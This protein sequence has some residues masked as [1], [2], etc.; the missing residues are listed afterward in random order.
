MTST[1]RLDIRTACGGRLSFLACAAL[2]ACALA[3]AAD[4]PRASPDQPPLEPLDSAA[5][6][7]AAAA[8]LLS[9]AGF[10]GTPAEIDALHAL[11]LDR[12]VE[13]ILDGKAPGPAA[14]APPREVPSL[15]SLARPVAR[16]PR[17]ELAGLSRE[18]RQKKV[19]ETRQADARQ[20]QSV[21]AAWIRRMAL[22]AHPLEEKLALFWHGHFATSQREVQSS[23]RMAVQNELFRS[24]GLGSFRDLTR[25]VARDP[26]MLRYLDNNQNRKG[27]PNE[28]FARELLELFTLGIGNYTEEDIKEAARA[29]TGWTFR[30]DG[31]VFQRRAHDDGT[32]TF[33]GRT[34]AFTG[35]EII[36]II[37]EQPAASRFVSRKLFVFF[38]HEDPPAEAVEALAATLRSSG[39]EVRAVLSQ[40]FRSAEFYSARAR[41]TRVKSPVELV[42]GT[43]RLLGIDP[44][45]SP[46]LAVAAGRMGQDL[47]LPPS[48]KGW[49]GGQAWI[50]TKT[51]F[52]RYN[53]A[54]ALLGL[55]GEGRPGRGDAPRGARGGGGRPPR[56]DPAAGA[57]EI[58][59]KDWAGLPAGEVVER[60]ARR[61]L[62]VQLP[63]EARTKLVAFYES[64]AGG[65]TARL[66]ELIHL[67][68]SSPEY[69]MG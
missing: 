56:W 57:E 46:F 17:N 37:F 29:L 51:L 23:H 42:V 45:E 32:K 34:G 68:L 38:A 4:P 28:N 50:S 40:L 36:D 27:R 16:P 67:L 48:V 9:R 11:G 47:F 25:A 6:D 15:L 5:F 24:G 20:F 3:R 10:G 54:R 61:F 64:A 62:L 44:G 1:V 26:A 49:D 35:D 53:F 66:A 19:R 52:D 41:G 60:L 33:L 22:T 59:G 21:R 30:D 7:R 69:Q 58:L 12:A 18:E 65:G 31:F 14:G 13:A 39:F 2:L 55:D 8:H 43:A 63:E